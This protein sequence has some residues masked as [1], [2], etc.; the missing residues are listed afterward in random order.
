MSELKMD[1]KVIAW[2]CLLRELGLFETITHQSVYLL[3]LNYS[4]TAY[5]GTT[6][7]SVGFTPVFAFDCPH[8]II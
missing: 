3:I 2:T 1:I 5:K 6:R 8:F 4:K 7:I